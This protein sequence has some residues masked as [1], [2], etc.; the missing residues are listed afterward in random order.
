MQPALSLPACCDKQVFEAHLFLQRVS[1]LLAA[2]PAHLCGLLKQP[3]QPKTSQLSKYAAH[4][5]PSLCRGLVKPLKGLL[6]HPEQGPLCLKAGDQKRVVEPGKREVRERVK[7][8]GYQLQL[9][10]PHR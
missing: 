3:A 10:I 4:L 1:F 5:P 7:G 6:S 9:W 2:S 8:L